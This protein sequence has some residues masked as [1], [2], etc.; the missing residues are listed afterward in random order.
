MLMLWW[1]LIPSC[2][3]AVRYKPSTWTRPKRGALPKGK[4]FLA[5][6]TETRRRRVIALP[7]RSTRADWVGDGWFRTGANG[8]LAVGTD[9]VGPDGPLHEAPESALDERRTRQH[10]MCA[11]L[12]G[13]RVNQDPAYGGWCC[14][15]CARWQCRADADFSL[16]NMVPH[17]EHCPSRRYPKWQN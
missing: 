9:V 12:W 14:V 13:F 7:D 1:V 5:D 16:A 4:V 8:K 2:V 10:L 6:E 3:N 17:G 11:G 15:S